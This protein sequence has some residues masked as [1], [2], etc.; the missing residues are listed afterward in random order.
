MRICELR[1]KEVINTKDGKILGYVMDVEFDINTGKLV[2]VIV[3]GPPRVWG[4]F[5]REIDYVIPFCKICCIGP[6]TILVNVCMEDIIVK[7]G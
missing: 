1:N 5:C 6:D 2:A 3:P 4:L 7:C